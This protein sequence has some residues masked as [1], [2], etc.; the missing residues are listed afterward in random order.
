MSREERKL[1]GLSLIEA[2]FVTREQLDL[3]LKK[4]RKTG[5]TLG[6]TL[7]K[8]GYLSEQQLLNFL[9][10]KLGFPHAN[11]ANYVVDSSIISLIPEDIAR[12]YQ[13][14]PLMKVKN[15]LTVAMLDPL[16]T[17]V[18]EN[19]KYTTGCDI[20]PLV[21]TKDEIMQAID[22]YYKSA[23]DAA[24]PDKPSRELGLK[25]LRDFASRVQGIEKREGVH[26][27]SEDAEAQ[28]ASIIHL[29]N[30]ILQDGIK[31]KA[32]DIHIEPDARGLRVR[33]RID[34]ILEEVMNLSTDWA[35]PVLSRTK[36]MAELDI[37]EKRIPHDGRAQIEID[38]RQIDLRVS[39]F[40]TVFGEKA[41][42]RILDKTN[43][44]FSL[45][46]LGFEEDVVRRFSNLIKS[47]NGII[48]ITGP[49]GSGKTSTLYAA[50]KEISDVEKNVVTIEDPVE[51]QLTMV[52]QAQINPKAGF[53][54]ASGLRSVLRQ[55]PDIIM[56]GEIRDLETAETAVRAAQTG[57]L[58]FSTLHTNDAAGAVTRLIDMGV[59]PFLVASSVIGTM[60]QRLVRVICKECKEPTHISDEVLERLG[61]PKERIDMWRFYEGR[62][63]ANCKDT[64]FRG[65]ACITEM[66]LM[67]EALR[68]LVVT[69]SPS[70]RIKL[71][72]RE[73]GMRTLRED[74]LEKAGRGITTLG[75]VLRVT[76][77]DEA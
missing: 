7:L 77:R 10:S 70:S 23:R 24:A 55:D 6:Y 28:K 38:G 35:A 58:V 52:N 5:D 18:M 68:N 69:K 22:K 50:L 76:Q 74:G 41:V 67:N 57:H 45:E 33:F 13:V 60:A 40:P 31:Y 4:H 64:G 32:S 75:E 61:A 34:G 19:I 39:T 43:V 63:C 21:S 1:L 8:L 66:M 11:L 36:V 37:S 2:G 42:L 44:V 59:E 71:K 20:K 49:T 47:P 12:K 30:R 16:D 26:D 48:L 54:F 25:E 17:F 65:R 73:M 29:V 3:A 56:V 53:T 51:Y 72:A 15:S 46:E 27:I 9:E 14:F 62:G